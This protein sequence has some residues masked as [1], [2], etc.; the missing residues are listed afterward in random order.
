M[1]PR[2]RSDRLGR[3]LAEKGGRSEL[4]GH[5]VGIN[6]YHRNLSDVEIGAGVHREFVG[7]LWDR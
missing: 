3:K 5:M 4:A 1:K 2:P 6:A 7:D